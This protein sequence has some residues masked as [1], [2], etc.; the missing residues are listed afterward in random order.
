[1]IGS[2]VAHVYVYIFTSPFFLYLLSSIL[3]R[4]EELLHFNIIENLKCSHGCMQVN[5]FGAVLHVKV[6]ILLSTT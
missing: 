2:K 6:E 3:E 5:K 1:M 4:N